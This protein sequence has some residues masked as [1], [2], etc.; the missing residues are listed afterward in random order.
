MMTFRNIAILAAFALLAVSC[1]GCQTHNLPWHPAD[2]FA[3]PV[4]PGPGP[5]LDQ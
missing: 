3:I 5:Y 2:M 1:A 4:D